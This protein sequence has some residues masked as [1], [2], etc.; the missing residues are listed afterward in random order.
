MGGNNGE[1]LT[2]GSSGEE[3]DGAVVVAVFVSMSESMV[4]PLFFFG[5][6]RSESK[7]KTEFSLIFI[8]S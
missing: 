3:S 5:F 2:G 4:N 6:E 1:G 8:V 7:N